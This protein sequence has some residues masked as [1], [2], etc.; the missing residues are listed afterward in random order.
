MSAIGKG[1]LCHYSLPKTAAWFINAKGSVTTSINALLQEFHG[2]NFDV[3]V[4][5]L[6]RVSKPPH[7]VK[8][9]WKMIVDGVILT[10]VEDE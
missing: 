8:G 10:K 5:T 6:K 3:G 7:Q 4:G 2:A 9:K 1:E